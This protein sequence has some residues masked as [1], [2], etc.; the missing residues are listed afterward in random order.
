MWSSPT[1]R[2]RAQAPA[3]C[4]RRSRRRRPSA[5]SRS[6][7]SIRPTIRP[8]RPTTATTVSGPTR[9]PRHR[10]AAIRARRSASSAR[11]R[12]TTPAS[13]SC[14]NSTSRFRCWSTRAARIWAATRIRRRSRTPGPS[15]F[16]F[17]DP[18]FPANY[19]PKKYTW[20]PST[21]AVKLGGT[22]LCALAG[23]SCSGSNNEVIQAVFNEDIGNADVIG[24]EPFYYGYTPARRRR[25]RASTS[26]ASRCTR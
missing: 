17:D 10:S 24:G 12:S 1:M 5:A 9:R 21:L 16:F 20:Y 18:E 8:I 3:R 7:S 11:T 19:L 4:R 25:R 13:N 14:S 26:S 2:R 23:G 15:T 22:S 6:I